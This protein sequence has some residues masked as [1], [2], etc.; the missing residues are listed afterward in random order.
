MIL[1]VGLLGYG[2]AVLAIGPTLFARLRF[3]RDA[4]AWAVATWLSALGSALFSIGVA[5]LLALIS[6][7]GHWAQ[8]GNELVSCLAGLRD[9]ALGRSGLGAQLVT[10]GATVAVLGAGVWFVA[11]VARSLHH[12]RASAD[13][14]AAAV[15]LV[16]RTLDDDVVV[17]DAPAPAA[18]CVM[19][20]T[21]TIVVTSSALDVLE[22][23]ELAAVLAHERAHLVG[24]HALVIA[25]LRAVASALP[26][27]SLLRASIQRIPTLLE[28]C[29]D[30]VAA[31]Q[32]GRGPLVSGLVAMSQAH[33]P[34]PL[35]L[36]AAEVALLARAER[37][38][39]PRSRWLAARSSAV[40]SGS[41]AVMIVVP[42]V[43]A[44]LATVGTLMC[45]P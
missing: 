20:R 40:L 32:H 7:G 30:D 14:H 24:R 43:V 26:K 23:D 41:A 11:R 4:P 9:A 21:P 13:E 15:R 12:M 3:Q 31:R 17:V 5:L 16:G 19:G 2:V 29:A 8:A 45:V 6:I 22:D 34:R 27:L 33:T 36:A 18:Y 42:A 1:I 39:A 35:G 28:M 44:V 25:V 38:T 10:I 37:L